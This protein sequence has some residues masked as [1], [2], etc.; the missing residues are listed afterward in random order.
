[1]FRFTH[2]QGF[3][4]LVCLFISSPFQSAFSG[5]LSLGIRPEPSSNNWN[6]TVRDAIPSN[7]YTLASRPNLTSGSWHDTA[8]IQAGTGPTLVARIDCPS[9]DSARFFTIRESSREDFDGD[10]LDNRSEYDAGC[11]PVLRDT[12]GDL[13]TDYE[14]V[15]LTHSNPSQSGDGV[16]MIEDTRRMILAKWALIYPTP[17]VFTNQP[18]SP[19]DLID[20]ENL[21]RQLSGVFF[22]NKE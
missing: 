5:D 4:Y 13:F 21:L 18:G 20:L 8:V 7:A 19:A 15:A 3:V 10:G 12:D 17:P 6:L 22:T 2:Q 1:M 11:D 16:E 9:P 14:E